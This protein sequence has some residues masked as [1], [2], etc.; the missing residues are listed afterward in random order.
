MKRTPIKRTTPLTRAGSS[1]TRTPL[2]RGTKPLK[3]TPLRKRSVKMQ[4]KYDGPNGR[5]AF[6][7]GFLSEHPFCWVRWETCTGRSV[8]VHEAVPRG[9]GGD[10]LPGPK[11]ERQG[12][13]F[14]AVCRECHTE[15]DL[16]SARARDEGWLRDIKRS[17]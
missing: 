8:D 14:V 2:A 13:L 7:A 4:A 15:I 17:K 6:V 5:K 3:R 1:L 16:Q 9:I 10:I 12:Q 11:A